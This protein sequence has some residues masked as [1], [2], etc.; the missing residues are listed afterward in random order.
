M[1]Q[2]AYRLLGSREKMEDALQE[3]CLRAYRAFPSFQPRGD[4]AAKAWLFRILYRTCLD[5]LRRRQREPV[6]FDAA[7]ELAAADPTDTLA[8]RSALA[9]ALG[10]L[11]LELRG[12]LLLVDLIGFDYRTS[13]RLLG[14]R[15]GTVASR[16]HRA[17]ASLRLEL[18]DE[19]EKQTEVEK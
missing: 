10:A 12:P 11:P 1:R 13:A 15:T 14:L 7:E 2:F 18:G 6:S 8:A 9:A 19:I 3:A 5:D 17:R 4:E 16:L